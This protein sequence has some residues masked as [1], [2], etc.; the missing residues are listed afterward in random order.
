MTIVPTICAATL[1]RRVTSSVMSAFVCS[2]SESTREMIWP[3]FV[4]WKY[5]ERQAL[6]VAEHAVAQVARD[7][8]LERAPSWPPS[9]TK[10]FLSATIDDDRRSSSS[11]TEPAGRRDSGT[12]RRCGSAASVIQLATSSGSAAP[13]RTARSGTGSSSVN[14]KT[15]STRRDD[16]ARDRARHPPGV[17]TQERQQSAIHALSA[18]A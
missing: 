2:V 6:Q 11:A 15:S 17:R 12:R 10:T 14:E 4:R 1:E 3:V 7:V 16:V 9:Q 8:L 18:S 5:A 13:R